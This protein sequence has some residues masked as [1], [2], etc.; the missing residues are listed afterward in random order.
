MNMLP[1]ICSNHE[2]DFIMMAILGRNRRKTEEE[3]EEYHGFDINQPNIK[4]WEQGPVQHTLSGEETPGKGCICRVTTA[5]LV[6]FG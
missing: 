6:L 2:I 5:F 3:E 1:D 4:L